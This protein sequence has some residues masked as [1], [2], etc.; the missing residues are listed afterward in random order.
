MPDGH[1]LRIR[2]R[3]AHVKLIIA[4]P[5]PY[6]R[7]ARIA[8]IEKSIDYEEIVDNPWLPGTGIAQ[9]NPLGKVPSLILDDGT[10]VHDSTVIVEYL[11]TLGREPRLIPAE[12]ALRVAHK[13]IEA[14]ADG[15][16][17]AIVLSV[18]ER[19]RPEPMRSS[20]WL[21]RQRRKIEA[22]SAELSRLLSAQAWFTS[23]GFALGEVATGCALGYIDLRYPEFDWRARHDNLTR[24]FDRVSERPS[25]ARTI[26]RAQELPVQH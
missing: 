17:D 19:A 6:A 26:P 24:L 2:H 9:V 25:F 15:L 5:S 23:A 18:L 7:K 10:V 3:Q 8:L 20:D 1:Y 12:P 22:A 21:T 4:T 13:Q 16:C 14:V 11:D